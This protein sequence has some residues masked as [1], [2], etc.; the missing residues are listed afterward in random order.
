LKGHVYD[1][2]TNANYFLNFQKLLGIA[3]GVK[4]DNAESQR[5][6]I[7]MY[8]LGHAIPWDVRK[9][10]PALEQLEREGKIKGLVLDAGCGF[11]DNGIYLAQKGYR[12]VGFDFSPEA[13]EIA[14]QRAANAGVSHLTEWVVADA[15]NVK[16]SPLR[17]RKF[18]TVLDSACLQCFDPKTQ[19]CYVDNMGSILKSSGTFV[20]LV[21]CNQSQLRSWCRGLRWMEGHV[22]DLF[23]AQTGWK[24]IET[25]RVTFIENIPSVRISKGIREFHATTE[26]PCLRMIAQPVRGWATAGVVVAGVVAVA[27]ISAMTLLRRR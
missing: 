1:M 9:A 24:I 3:K 13:I 23:S 21:V 11:G 20:L 15:L 26:S 16:D 18:D 22:S 27:A 19:R 17:G 7:E 12:V 14:V 6:I 10:Q 4:V 5:Q 2:F 25:E 8:K